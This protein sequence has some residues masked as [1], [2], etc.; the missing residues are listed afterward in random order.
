MR[1]VEKCF[2]QVEIPANPGGHEGDGAESFRTDGRGRGPGGG[3]KLGFDAA[4]A[5]APISAVEE[6][7]QPLEALADLCCVGMTSQ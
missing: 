6:A 5:R 2:R 7:Q 4:P 1:P 3:K